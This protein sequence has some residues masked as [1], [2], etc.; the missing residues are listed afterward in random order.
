M[1]HILENIEKPIPAADEGE[2]GQDDDEVKALETGAEAKVC[3]PIPLLN[4]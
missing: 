4:I 3:I 1:D 2:D